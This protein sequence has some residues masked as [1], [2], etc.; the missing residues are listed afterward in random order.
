M[1]RTGFLFSDP[2]WILGI[3]VEN[4]MVFDI[5][6][7]HPVVGGGQEKIIIEADFPRTGSA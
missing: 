7:W 1:I 3:K 2:Q 5:N 4:P 6:L